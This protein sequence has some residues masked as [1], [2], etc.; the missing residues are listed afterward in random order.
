[1]PIDRD[2]GRNPL[3]FTEEVHEQVH[4]VG[5][6]DEHVLATGTFVFLAARADFED[7]SD[8]PLFEDL[9][10]RMSDMRC[11]PLLVSYRP[12]EVLGLDGRDHLIRFGQI[13]R[14]GFLHVAMRSHLRCRQEVLLVAGG[15][16]WPH[17]DEIGFLG[18]QHLLVVSIGLGGS[19]ILAELGAGLFMGIGETHHLDIGKVLPGQVELVAILAILPVADHTSPVFLRLLCGHNTPS[20]STGHCQDTQGCQ[21]FTPVLMH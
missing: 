11:H 5:S 1:M 16:T 20:E 13:G 18:G 15:E 10:F 2:V 8:Q 19:S 17:R 14:Q 12:L 6:Q 4:A 21:E 7:V 3:G 9:L